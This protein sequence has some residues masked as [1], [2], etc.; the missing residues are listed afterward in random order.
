ME[1]HCCGVYCGGGIIAVGIYRGGESLLW[2]FIM[3]GNHCCEC[4]L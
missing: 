2:V 3:V 4:L 1:N